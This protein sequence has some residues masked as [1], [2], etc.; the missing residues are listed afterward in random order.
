MPLP[1]I[2]VQSALL[3][4]VLVDA[5]LIGILLHKRRLGLIEILMIV[6]LIGVLGWAGSVFILL[7]EEARIAAHTSYAFA[8]ILAASKY[9]FALIFPENALPKGRIPYAILPITLGL[10]GITLLDGA[11][12]TEISVIGGYAISVENGPLAGIYSLWVTIL[13]IAPLIILRRKARTETREPLRK[14]LSFLWYGYV[15]FFAIGLLTNSILPVFFDIDAFNGVG[16]SFSLVLAA[17]MVY[18]ITQ[19]RFLDI[20]FVVQRSFLFTLLLGIAIGV[21]TA[22]AAAVGVAFEI[23]ADVTAFASAGIT[24]IL[25]L[26]GI[27]A[28]ERIFRTWTDRIFFKDHY[29]LPLAIREIT[30]ILNRNNRTESIATE[31]T[32]ALARILRAT[33]VRIH[34]LRDAAAE[35]GIPEKD[36]EAI[37]QKLARDIPGETRVFALSE[38]LT[39][40]PPTDERGAS[41]IE[42]AQR[43]MDESRGLPEFVALAM[44]E[45]RVLATLSI[46]EKRSGDPFS[47]DD[48]ALLENISLQ[49]AI[50][51]EK[52]LLYEEQRKYAE[53]LEARVIERTQEIATLQEEQRRMMIDLSHGLQ[54]PLAIMKA[55]LA[56][57]ESVGPADLHELEHSIDHA[58]RYIYDLLSLARLEHGNEEPPTETIDLAAL[59]DELTEYA[60]LPAEEAGIALS[61]QVQTKEPAHILGREKQLTDAIVNILGNAVKY[62]GERERKEIAVS[63]E[64]ENGRV[65]LRITDT[66]PGIDPEFLPHLF[67]R[68]RRAPATSGS[69]GTGIG[70]AIAKRVIELH[71]GAIEVESAPGGGTTFTLTFPLAAGATNR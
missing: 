62:M 52:A 7:S 43:R 46:W 13:L 45:D 50:A 57:K 70:L 22:V 6:H 18:I 48:L 12:F 14:Q 69:R 58:S 38:L 23:A 47:K 32:A 39:V 28:L 51:L 66:G 42:A 5:L 54:T 20:R 10:A 19:H 68:F 35:L 56:K 29:D 71:G 11:L 59:V 40:I 17:F 1:A 9:W 4:S 30:G 64:T 8:L 27:P 3:L 33:D 55:S 21:Y 65:H 26:I 49:T 63:L 34:L 25:G 41:I 24:L 2:A 61:S 37:G 16:P 60:A 44:T 15:I 36:L 31:L 53:K 67:E